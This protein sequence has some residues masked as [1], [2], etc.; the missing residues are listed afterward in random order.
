MRVRAEIAWF[1]PRQVC[2][3][4]EL[5][6]A[7][8]D[9]ALN[10]T[11]LRIGIP[12]VAIQF[13]AIVLPFLLG[14][15][16]PAREPAWVAALSWVGIVG[17]AALFILGLGYYAAAKGHSRWAGL[18]GMLSIIGYLVLALLPDRRKPRPAPAS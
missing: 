14:Y 7:R 6:G 16:N 5:E 13:T 11:S 10:R 18:L 3:A 4:L 2:V 15:E 1:G 12:G 9:T 17:G 8:M